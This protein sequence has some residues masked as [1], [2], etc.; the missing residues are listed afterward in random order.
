MRLRPTT[1]SWFIGERRFGVCSFVHAYQNVMF[2]KKSNGKLL[3]FEK[4]WALRLFV[5]NEI[6][7]GGCFQKTNDNHKSMVFYEKITWIFKNETIRITSTT[8]SIRMQAADF[9]DLTILPVNT[10]D[11][12]H[13]FEFVDFWYTDVYC[14][15]SNTANKHCHSISLVLFS[16][17]L[18]SLSRKQDTIANWEEEG[19]TFYEFLF[20]CCIFFSSSRK[21]NF[22][23]EKMSI[24][25][26]EVKEVVATGR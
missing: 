22:M 6:A 19:W 5:A 10:R 3:I 13:S 23:I 15:L 2:E 25:S 20:F 12:L 11:A 18:L 24:S 7:I 14:C 4:H 1:V 26:G 9:I 17:D 8:H 21:Y 16:C